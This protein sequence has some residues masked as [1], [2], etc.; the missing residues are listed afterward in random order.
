M[1]SFFAPTPTIYK[2]QMQRNNLPDQPQRSGIFFRKQGFAQTQSIL[3][4]IFY[5][6]FYRNLLRILD[7]LQ[8]AFYG[9]K[10]YNIFKEQYLL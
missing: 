5:V 10:L 1:E 7:G 6:T 3:F 8:I 4:F 9:C 2:N